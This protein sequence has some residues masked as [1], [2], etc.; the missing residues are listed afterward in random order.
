[1]RVFI[2]GLGVVSSIGLGKDAFFEALRAGKSGVGPVESFD[3]SSLGRE[4]AGEVK[5]F[6]PRDH[7]SVVETRRMGRCSQM[8]LAAA[9]MAIADSGLRREA[10]RGP[11]ASVVL[12]TTMGE[13]DVLED[14]DHAWIEKGLAA[15][16][17]AW[18]PKYGSTLL[19]I[20]IARAIGSEGMVLTLPAACAAGN[21]AIGFACDLIRAK[22]ADVVITGA[23]EMLQELQ[24]MGFVRLA[25]MA[26]HRCQPF[27]LNRQGII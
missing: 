3:V 2:T 1:M 22:R 16:R 13:A 27:D 8:A 26:P 4:L 9:R 18:L 10:L 17:R 19:P 21:Y 23:A 11:R 14:L 15:V 25:A 20:H 5:T 6:R 12:G 24:F 7:L